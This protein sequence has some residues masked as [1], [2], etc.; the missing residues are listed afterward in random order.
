MSF[1]IA[2]IEIFSPNTGMN[3]IE[4]L[5]AENFTQNYRRTD[6]LAHVIEVRLTGEE[7]DLIT[8]GVEEPFSSFGMLF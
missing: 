1:F 2:A 5:A 6:D 7:D 8:K 4:N 3:Q